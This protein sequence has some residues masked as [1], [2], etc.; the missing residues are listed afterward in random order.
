MRKIIFTITAIIVAYVSAFS[1]SLTETRHIKTTA[2]QMYE[3]YKVEL[4]GLYSRSVYTEDHFMRLFESGAMIYNDILPDNYPQQLSPADYFAKFQANIMRIYPVF[5]DFKMGEP[6]SKGNKWQ[7]KC[8]FARG[9]RYRTQKDMKY[10]EWL[11]RYTLTIEMD[12]RYD[13]NKKVYENAK[14][15]SVDVEN[16]LKGFFV[17]EN[18]E[19]LPLAAKSGEML[20]GWDEEYQ[21]RIFPDDQ[22]KI[23]DIKVLESGN[24]D[25]IFTFSKNKFSKNPTDAHFYQVD[26]QKFKK[27]IMGIGI[28]YSPVALGN[29]ISEAFRDSIK[30]TSNAL[31]LSVFYGKQFTHKEKSTM[32][33]T[34]GLDFNRYYHQYNRSYSSSS[35]KIDTLNEKINL[36]SVS[37]PV[38]VQY[39]HQLI[40]QTKKPIFLSFELGVF[41]EYTLFSRSTYNL[42][43]KYLTNGDR[44]FLEGGKTLA[45]RFN[46]GLF[47]GI[48]LWYALNENNLLKFNVSYKHGFNSPLKYDEDYVIAE[49]KDSYQS[50]LHSTKQGMR[51]IGIGISWVKTIGG[52]K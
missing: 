51:N 41:A 27:N 20:K 21:S 49:N 34:F 31:S 40:Q 48:G 14:I 26:V 10:P 24:N 7:I 2:L 30:H 6:E 36:I 22:W 38:S 12:K 43:V 19:H 15:V 13:A 17:I 37:L 3:Q 39:L 47:C 11:F 1:Q 32:F 52:K 8:N 9:T 23:A 4:S 35:V 33:F 44:Y 16:P 42:N 46:G 50:L 28:N 29:K 45:K 5:S 25:N 18:K